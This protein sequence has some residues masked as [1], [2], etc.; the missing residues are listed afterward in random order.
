MRITRLRESVR[1]RDSLAFTRYSFVPRAPP[2]AGGRPVFVFDSEEK[3]AGLHGHKYAIDAVLAAVAGRGAAQGTQTS[4][5]TSGTDD[6]YRLLTVE[7]DLG[8]I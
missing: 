7:I 5:L 8:Q 6:M 4:V 3:A 1:S 2:I